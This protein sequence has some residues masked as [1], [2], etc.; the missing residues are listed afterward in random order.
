VL[1]SSHE[2]GFRTP[3]PNATVDLTRPR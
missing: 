1:G 2:R 3:S